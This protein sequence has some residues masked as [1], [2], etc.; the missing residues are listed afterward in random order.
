MICPHCKTQIADGLPFCSNC[1]KQ[2]SVT[3]S[4]QQNQNNANRTG[5]IFPKNPP[6]S[7]YLAAL[8]L[9]FP[10]IAQ[11]VYGQVAK[12]VVLFIASIVL[13][14]I[15]GI[16]LIVLIAAVVDAYMV[17]I[18]LQGGRPVGQWQFFPS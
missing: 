11:L 10:G 5:L 14:P 17:G 13:L 3:V 12:G 8:N 7:P 18:Y 15:A 16:G 9:L 2:T 6:L 1:G 4:P